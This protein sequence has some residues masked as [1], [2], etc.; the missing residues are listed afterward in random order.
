MKHDLRQNK[1]LLID[2]TAFEQKC[3]FMD[4]LSPDVLTAVGI[5]RQKTN[6]FGDPIPTDYML[7][8]CCV[9][10]VCG[11][12]VAGVPD[13]YKAYGF[14][15]PRDIVASVRAAQ[16]DKSVEKT[17]IQFD[18][19]GGIVTGIPELGSV[20]ADVQQNGKKPL[21]GFSNSLVCS[22][23]YWAA[24]GAN[25]LF[26]T[27]SSRWGNV[28]AYFTFLNEKKSLEA[29]GYTIEVFKSVPYKAMGAD[30]DLTDD[31]REL[32]QSQIMD[33]HQMFASYVQSFRPIADEDLQGQAFMGQAAADKGFIDA[34]VPDLETAIELLR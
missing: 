30:G 33:L 8:S 18:T 2:D 9:I 32:I 7:G 15:D 20:I 19:P 22:G 16:E 28:G 29:M 4:E 25:A 11:V 26:G 31:Q 5:G 23:G 27:P 1:L 21:G 17:M 14:C 12:L 6:V 34:V 10:P 3:R 24:A 13:F